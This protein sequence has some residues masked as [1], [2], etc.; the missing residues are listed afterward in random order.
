MLFYYFS[1]TSVFPS[2]KRRFMLKTVKKFTIPV[3][4]FGLFFSPSSSLSESSPTLF[5]LSPKSLPT[6]VISMISVFK[7]PKIHHTCR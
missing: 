6:R 4:D 3:D 7:L 2:E 5:S 1:F